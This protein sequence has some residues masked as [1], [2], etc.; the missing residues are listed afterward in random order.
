MYL[1]RLGEPY[2]IAGAAAFLCSDDSTYFMGETMVIA[3]G[4]RA[5]L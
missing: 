3:G 1:R 5:H 4:D 2:E